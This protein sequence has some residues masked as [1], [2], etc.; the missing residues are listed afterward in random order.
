MAKPVV[1][2]ILDGWGVSDKQEG[3]A[4]SAGETPVFDRLNKAKPPIRIA[5]S[6]EEVG[7][8]AGIMGNSEV[9]H[10]SIGAGRV[11]YQNLLRISNSI[12][13][14]SFFENK[15]IT[16]AFERAAKNNSALHLL[17]LLSDGGVHSDIKHIV[18]LIELAQQKGLT[19]VFIHP[20]M[21]G[22]DT[23]PDSGLGYIRQLEAEIKRI[24]VGAIATVAGRFYAMDRDKRWERV[25]RAYNLLTSGEGST[26][27]SAEEAIKANYENKVTDEFVEPSVITNGEGK[28]LGLIADGD[29]VLTF[30]FRAD[31]MRE[32]VRALY[33]P[34]FTAFARKTAP[35]VN[36]T[37]MAEYD[38]S[39]GLP[40][41]FAPQVPDKG[42]GETLSA[43]G[44]TQLRTAETEK[45]AH[46]TF[47]FN[48]GVELPFKN[49]ERKLV[50]SPRV[51]TYDLKPE[52]SCAEVTDIV[53]SAIKN[54]SYDV[55][56]ANLANGDMVGHTGIWEAAIKAVGVID[57]AVG[58][59]I[60]AAQ[61]AEAQL[62]ITADHGNIETM[63]DETGKPMTAHTTNLVPFYYLGNDSFKLTGNGG[64]LADI[65]PTMLHLL[66]LEQPEEMTGKSLLTRNRVF[67]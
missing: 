52:M 22:R 14:G 64:C 3:N 8:P 48:G 10:L 54:R 56:I 15:A 37:C 12:A 28:P 7:L 34:S 24:G 26:C 17:G 44:L 27:G 9:G 55:I 38:E 16:N 53:V 63:F 46:V 32:I 58:R 39:Y 20:F 31:R 57:T 2:L 43:H 61:E 23:P 25:E 18:A 41:A 33:D 30:N 13:D 1:L 11:M 50:S 5:A 49:E 36:V 29:E 19:K 59:I 6:G 67:G 35:R 4:I 60:E 21:D 51:R 62:L 65:A 45:Y 42:L 66:G 40:L 47:F